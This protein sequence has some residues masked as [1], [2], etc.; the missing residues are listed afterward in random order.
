MEVMVDNLI[1]LTSEVIILLLIDLAITNISD[2][3]FLFQSIFHYGGSGN[4]YPAC[5]V[6]LSRIYVNFDFLL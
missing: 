3:Q 4:K 1:P 6:N 5:E 2:T